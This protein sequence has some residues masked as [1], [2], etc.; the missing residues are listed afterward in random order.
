MPRDEGFAVMDLST[1]IAHDPKFRR[2]HRHYPELVG[3][4]F[5]VYLTTLAESWKA[6]ARLPADEVWPPILPYRE[7]V[8][9]ALA[10]VGLLDSR[11]LVSVKAWRSWFDPANERRKKSRDRWRRYNESREPNGK[12]HA[13]TTSLPRGDDAATASSVPSRTEPFLSEPSAVSSRIEIPDGRSDIEAYVLVRR[14]AP[15]P[16]QRALL[17]GV[18]DRHDLTGAKWAADIIL[19][20]PN[21]PIGAVI[22]A[23]K[24]WRSERIAEAVAAEKPKPQARRCRGLPQSARDILA[25]MQKI[26]AEKGA[27]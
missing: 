27:A 21:D 22:E 2:L 5:T 1:D 6:G 9:A 14:Q 25:E 19:R 16:R 13:D 26:E 3:D 10:E 15:T 11:N 4:C 23:D 7:Q 12:S 8:I 20:N 24:A 18:L 17:D